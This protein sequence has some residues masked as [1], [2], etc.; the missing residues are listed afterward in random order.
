[1]TPD[2]SRSRGHG[3][4]L[5]RKKQDAIKALMTHPTIEKAAGAVGISETTLWRWLQLPEFAN[6]YAEARNRVLEQ[7]LSLLHKATGSAVA[8]LVRNLKC[9]NPSVEVRAAIGVLD[10]TF[11][12]RE[13]L[14]M[15]QRLAAVEMTLDEA[16][17]VEKTVTSK[18]GYR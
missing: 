17:N 8:T 5:D 1:M 10:Q 9:G 15:E 2:E 13:L 4:K 14:E 3:D 12:A 6:A 16:K 7:T 11:K 18:F